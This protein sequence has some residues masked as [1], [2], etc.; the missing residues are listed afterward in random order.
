MIDSRI[1]ALIPHRP[2]FLWVDRIIDITGDTLTCEKDIDANLELFSGH[3][4]DFPIMPGVLVCEAIFQAG[5]LLYGVLHQGK[6]GEVDGDKVPVLAK[7]NHAKFK[8]PVMPGATLFISVSLMET[9][10]HISHFKGSV[11]VD[12]E[13]CVKTDFT[14][15]LA[16]RLQ[17]S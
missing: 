17:P 3:Y 13:L 16:P 11:H 6:Q 2:P 15:A 12:N 9:Y 1:A 10:G 4:P 8:R 7:I 5:A 14:T